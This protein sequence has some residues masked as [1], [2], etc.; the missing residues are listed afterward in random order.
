VEKA[1]PGM[2]LVAAP[3]LDL[4]AAPAEL[5]RLKHMPVLDLSG[6]QP[7]LPRFKHTPVLDLS[8]AQPWPQLPQP[9]PSQ[10]YCND[11]SY[12]AQLLCALEFQHGHS[13]CGQPPASKPGSREHT[14]GAARAESPVKSCTGDHP[15][16]AAPALSPQLL[17]GGQQAPQQ[18][19]QWELGCASPGAASATDSAAHFVSSSSGAVPT[20]SSFSLGLSLD[21]G[22]EDEPAAA[23]LGGALEAGGVDDELLDQAIQLGLA[24]EVTPAQP[25]APAWASTR[26]LPAMAPAASR[27]LTGAPAACPAPQVASYTTAGG[28]LTRLCIKLQVG[29]CPP[30]TCQPGGLAAW[31]ATAACFVS[32]CARGAC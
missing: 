11:H 12:T 4:S 28:D 13:H 23:G 1:G 15:L 7:E 30:S 3:G 31:Q 10:L 16:A 22:M 25:C 18:S 26:G 14:P 24:Q 2:Q 19:L 20:A 5:P 27:G 17:P 29:S 9:Q 32:T 6:P 21:L 8:S